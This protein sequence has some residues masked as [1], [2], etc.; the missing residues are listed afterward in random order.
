MKDEGKTKKQLIAELNE[1]R[2][3][4]ATLEKSQAS[5]GQSANVSHFETDLF[6]LFFEFNP[7]YC[8]LISP[9]YE[10]LDVNRAALRIL[11]YNKPTLVGQSIK[12]IYT[13][14]SL[15]KLQDI[16]AQLDT[17]DDLVNEELVIISKKG[18][19]RTIILSAYVVKDEN[20]KITHY[21]LIQ[22]ELTR[23]EKT[24]EYLRR[25]EALLAST[26]R[27]TKVGGW[28]W[29]V[30]KQTMFW[31]DE[32]YRIHGY[33]PDE[34]ER[35]SSTHI[36]R[37]VECYRPEDQ[38][39]ILEV[40]EKCAKEGESYDIE[41]PL[42]T[43]QGQTKW[44]RTAAKAVRKNGQVVKVIG[45]I[46]D[47]TDRKRIEDALKKSELL[48]RSIV[49]A[50]PVCIYVKDFHGKYIFVNKFI[51][52]LY[53]T[54][55]EEMIGKTDL[56]FADKLSLAKED[57]LAFIHDNQEVI[58]NNQTKFVPEEPFTF[59]DGT[60]KWF[61]TTKLPISLNDNPNCMLGVSVDITEHKKVENILFE[62]KN[63]YSQLLEAI[64][65]S[66]YVLD[67]EWRHVIVNDAA[68]RFVR[69]PK[70]KLL[71]GK[72]TELFPGVE[73]TEFFNIFQRVMESR[74]TDIVVNEYTFEDGRKG[75]YEVSV[76][77]VPQGILCI[78]RDITKRKIAEENLRYRIELEKLIADVSTRFIGAATDAID[79]EINRT[80][81]L[82]GQ[83]T[84]VDRS[85][86]FLI[87][88]DSK[89]LTNTH[90]WCAKGIEPQIENL[91]AVPATALPWWMEKLTLFKN[92][93]VPSVA[94][95]PAE[96]DSEQKILQAQDIQSVLVVPVFYSQ[97]LLGFIGF[98]SVKNEKSWTMEDITLLRTIG[99]IIANKLQSNWAKK[100]IETLLQNL[101][102]RFKEMKQLYQ[103]SQLSTELNQPLD[104][105]L[106]KTVDAIPAA[107]QHPELTCA[108]IILNEK[109]FQT[110]N[111]QKTKWVQTVDIHVRGSKTGMIE[112][113]Y[114]KEIPIK[115]EGPFL[116]EERVLLES[117]ASHIANY[118]ERKQAEE[119]IRSVNEKLQRIFDSSTS[120]IIVVDAGGKITEWNR[121][122][123]EIFGWKEHEVIGKFNPTVPDDMHD[124]YFETIRKQ[125]KNIEIKALRK[126]HTLVDILLSSAPLYD[127]NHTFI[128][129]VGVVSDITDR[130]HAEKEKAILE[131]KLRRSQKMETIGT[132]AG[133][134]A[135]D[136]NN[137]LTPIMGYTD[138]AIMSMA[139]D[140]PLVDD[141]K[142]VLKGAQR[143][144]EL[145]KQILTFSRQI[146]QERK[147]L[148]IHL[149]VKEAIKLLRPSIPTTI[150]IRQRIDVSCDEVLADPSQIHQV[151]V[152]LCTNAYQ[153]LEEKGGTL[154][155][156]L[157]QV[158]IDATAE[159]IHLN[160]K[161]GEY[162]RLTVSD[163]GIGMETA[164]IEHIFEP[165]FTTKAVDK[166][167]GMGLS[168]VHGIVRS[169]QGEIIVHSKL[170]EGSTFH[171][172]L[173][174]IKAGV[175]NYKM[176]TSVI[177]GGQETILVVDDE[178]AVAKVMKRMLV[179]LGYNVSVHTSSI[180]A[181][182]TV[183]QRAD[184][185]DLVISD[186]TM[187]EM[188][189]LDLS[190]QL[191][192]IQPDLPIVLMTGYGENVTNDVIKQ[193]GIHQ[194]IG[195][196]IGMEFL[197]NC[198]RNVFTS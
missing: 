22:K 7:E 198:V 8:L 90:E 168:V 63:N 51:A 11:E 145:V 160:L 124:F 82:V 45:N 70:E 138:I 128:G 142:S 80:L 183:R 159:K 97:K 113:C 44:I 50:T 177:L 10:I 21:V 110:Q 96:A 64:S 152:N 76:Y 172:Y 105:F 181:L 9:H 139:P 98:D 116:K 73:K 162:V 83:F 167:T 175:E 65:D 191:H 132:L 89:T 127:E 195:K 169:H 19:R 197:A 186:L 24:K 149:V 23:F 16:L 3:Q 40:F 114:L 1:L 38:P 156:E 154:T 72:I 42:I 67:S 126:D 161:Q 158:E 144:K 59:P 86:L 94:N 117:L 130:K 189:G 157:K 135:H 187:P 61:Q 147:P 134:I 170:G 18:V 121:A 55:R 190:I 196:P 112:V 146:E 13:D 133:G 53:G 33:N 163:T 115:D 71:G 141:L 176:K 56:D 52:D 103:V 193:Y 137:I 111:F 143:A 41:F 173:P 164:T 54:T 136:F 107:W 4:V 62:S 39:V 99:E 6:R 34:I 192:K 101:R 29:D 171:V 104:D 92:I 166:G 79:D 35:G 60:I 180:E 106:Q 31:T 14:E 151:I 43:V 109:H 58:K 32:T 102:E 30:Q 174:T 66:V 120:G 178:E 88:K 49:D 48:L 15:A 155:I 69:M 27:L 184:K 46:I 85:Y 28:E 118:A 87:S 182:K 75:W 108:R 17:I 125:Q 185:Y 188:T 91:K 123:E 100:D 20:A 93:H 12:K 2:Q 95:M 57:A 129:T 148:K 74:E 81:R 84:N 37:S 179:K 122:S 26:Q 77:P 165:F 68:T 119:Q 194:V 131:T 47:I 25:S 36:D 78:S 153:S 5:N 140:D 150:E